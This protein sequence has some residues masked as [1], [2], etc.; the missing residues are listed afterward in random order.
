[1]AGG[2]PLLSPHLVTLVRHARQYGLSVTLTT[3]GFSLTGDL[4]RELA[5]AGLTD[6]SLSLDGFTEQHNLL[7][8]R[9]DAFALAERAISH[10]TDN[11]IVVRLNTVICQ[12]NIEILPGFVAW[13]RD[14]PRVEGVFFQVLSLPFGRAMTA[15]WWEAEPLFPR[16][17]ERAA[18]VVDQLAAIKRAGYPILNP[19]EQFP[20]LAA[21][22]RD[23]A[24]MAMQ[25]C[26]VGA[27]G[28]TIHGSG[29]I[30]LCGAFESIGDLRDGHH[31]RDVYEDEKAAAVRAKMADCRENCHLLINCCFDEDAA[32]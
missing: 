21:Y 4:A 10:A 28:L 24:S 16:D 32:R 8:Q 3:N 30:K 13:V 5:A 27:F 7:R 31:L 19:N 15:R 29:E 12:P 23:P 11:G 9:P 25:R 14:H 22:F 1:M 17:G 18:A 6:L 2:E 20:V 26:N